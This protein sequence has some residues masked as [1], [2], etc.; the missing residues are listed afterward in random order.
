MKV[1]VIGGGGREHALVWALKKCRRVDK[2]YCC[3]GNAGISGLAECINIGTDNIRALVDLVKCEWID[4]TVVGPEV[5]LGLG[6]VDVFEREGLKIFGPSQR[7]AM[8]ETSKVFAKDFMRRHAIPT[9]RYKVFTSYPQAEE[10]IR[11]M[12]AP[13]V[14][15]ADGLAAGKGVIVAAT[16]EEAEDAIRLIMADRVFGD[17]GDK[18]IIEERITG[19]EVSFMVFTDGKAIVPIPTSQDHKRVYDNDKGPNTGGMGAYSPAPVVDKAMEETIMET[20]MRPTISL[21]A[22]DGIKYKGVLYAG[23]MIREGKPYVLEYNCRFGDPEAQALLMRL[24]SGIVDIF[25]AVYDEALEAATIKWKPEAAVAVVM[26][27]G[28]YPGDFQRGKVITGLE[29]IKEPDGVCVF[30]SGTAFDGGYYATSSGRVLTVAAL[31]ENISEAKDNA[32]QAAAKIHFEDMHYRK[33]I[34]M[35]ALKYTG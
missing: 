18:V 16:H 15:K 32:Y 21:L 34:A 14:V 17:A 22:K 9:A 24:D 4:L 25:L 30:H 7:A 3:P 29:S 2:V 20:I 23:L 31:G 28:G 10:Y 19:E 13:I 12:G 26:A 35:R 6:I 11:L 27:A 8:L 5:P 1:L 33:D